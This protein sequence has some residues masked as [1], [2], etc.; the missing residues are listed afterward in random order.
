MI[1]FTPWLLTFIAFVRQCTAFNLTWSGAT[2]PEH[3]L[4]SSFHMG[5][6]VTFCH[7]SDCLKE[8]TAHPSTIFFIAFI[9]G[10]LDDNVVHMHL[11]WIAHMFSY[12]KYSMRFIIMDCGHFSH[13][14]GENSNKCRTCNL[15]C[16]NLV[17]STIEFSPD[18]TVFI[19]MYPHC[20]W[21]DED[22][23]FP[24]LYKSKEFSLLRQHYYGYHKPILIHG[25]HEQPWETHPSDMNYVGS[26]STLND[27]YSNFDLVFRHYYSKPHSTH[28]IYLPV[29]PSVYGWLKMNMLD[30]GAYKKA[31]QR[32][33]FCF[34]SGRFL[35]P[36]SAWGP[37]AEIERA[38]MKNATDQSNFHSSEISSLGTAENIQTS[39]LCEVHERKLTTANHLDMLLETVFALCPRGNN[40]ETFRFY[41]ALESGAI[42]VVVKGSSLEYDF[43]EGK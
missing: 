5:N 43:L 16:R 35:Y 4:F 20:R 15:Q 34:F 23:L 29:G 33:L 6:N 36:K 31:S 11:P 42:P 19:S 38:K 41:E 40:L 25:N 9:D 12:S 14:L 2:R 37:L 22:A 27:I 28:S 26:T 8:S 3:P 7:T 18:S 30:R 17:E 21:Q 1:V 24:N 39:K 32:S 13:N 10:R